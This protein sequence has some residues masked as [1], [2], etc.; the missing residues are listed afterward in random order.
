MYFDVVL[1]YAYVP[2]CNGTR[3]ECIEFLRAHKD[4]TGINNWTCVPGETME[5]LTVDDYM[6]R[7][8][9]APK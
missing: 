4:D 3:E 5:Q 2:L 9:E 7:Y 6:I 1:N 8:A